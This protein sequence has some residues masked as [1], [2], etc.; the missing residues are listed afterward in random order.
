MTYTE[1]LL[2]LNG[3]QRF[4]LLTITVVLVDFVTAFVVSSNQER[5]IYEDLSREIQDTGSSSLETSLLVSFLLLPLLAIVGFVHHDTQSTT[6]LRSRGSAWSIVDDVL[7]M[8]VFVAI[9]CTC[10]V[11]FVYWFVHDHYLISA[12]YMVSL[13]V[14]TTLYWIDTKHKRFQTIGPWFLSYLIL[15]LAFGTYFWSNGPRLT[16]MLITNEEVATQG[17]VGAF[18]EAVSIAPAADGTIYVGTLRG[19]YMTTDK[20]ASWKY[21]SKGLTGDDQVVHVLAVGNGA[22]YVRTERAIFRS[23]DRGDHWTNVSQGLTTAGFAHSLGMAMDGT[24]YAGT[25]EG[26]FKSMDGGAHWMA[27][28]GVDILASFIVLA[29][30]GA[31]YAATRQGVLR[32]TDNGANW[33]ATGGSKIDALYVAVAPDGSIFAGDFVHVFKSIDNG[34]H[35]TDAVQWFEHTHIRSLAIA[36]DGILYVATDHCIARSADNGATW[37]PITPTGLWCS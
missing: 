9:A 35:W 20:G 18:G 2:K 3:W 21:I 27:A 13:A 33:A 7:L 30:D 16:G 15:L 26:I 22:I 14:L 12:S 11:G 32:T 1:R 36:P 37:S 34:I 31:I 8:L 10:I 19:V 6:Q 25:R 29:P 23:T 28:S 17:L 5:N 24:I 4:L